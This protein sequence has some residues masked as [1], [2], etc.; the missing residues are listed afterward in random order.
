MGS[1]MTV[2]S[3]LPKISRMHPGDYSWVLLPAFCID[4]IAAHVQEIVWKELAHLCYDGIEKLKKALGRDVRKFRGRR[5]VCVER[6][7]TAM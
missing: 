5:T 4:L 1:G 2:C 6:R 3:H 7:S